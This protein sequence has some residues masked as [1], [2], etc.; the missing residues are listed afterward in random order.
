MADTIRGLTVEISADASSFNK[1]MSQM[2]KA[3]QSSQSELTALQ[4]SLDLEFDA[5]KLARAQ[6]VAQDAIDQTAANADALRRRL[7]YLEQ[8]GNIDTA[9]YSKLQTELAQTELK[10]QQLQKQLEKLNTLKFDKLSDQ[11][12]KIGSKI[13]GVGKALT[14]LSVAAAGV[15]TALGAAGTSAVKHAD[16]I[17]T[18]AT[19]YGTTA[20]AIQRFDY[21][22]LQ[23]DVDSENLYKALVKVRAGVADI[24]SG[25]TS[26]ASAALKKLR[27]DFNSFD[28]SEDQFYAIIDALASMEDQTQMVAIANDIFGD[29]LANS[30]LPLIY[31]GTDAVNEYCA[32]FET[33]GS[34]TNEQVA[35]LAE[36]DN[37]LNRIKTQLSNVKDQIGAALLPVMQAFADFVENNIVPKLQKLAGWFDSLSDS[38]KEFAVKALLVVAALAPLAIGIGKVVGAVGNVIKVLPQLGSALSALEAHPIIAIIGLIAM[39]LLLLYT[40][41][42]AFRDAINNLV[43]SLT[44]AL[45]PALEAVQNVLDLIMSFITPIIELVGGVLGEVINAITEALQP[46]NDILAEIFSLLQPIFDILTETI[47]TIL[48]PLQP[49]LSALF[50][51]LEPILSVALIPMKLVLQALQVPLKAIGTLL[52]WLAPL[53]QVFGNI[54]SKIFGGVIKIINLVLGVIEDA[55]NFVIGI[56]NGLVDGVNKALGW[57][58]VHIDRIAEVKLRIDTSDI[59]SMDDVNAI[60]DST[61]PDTSGGGTVYDDGKGSG[62]YGDQYNYD[63]STTNKTQNITVTIQNYAAEI[64]EDELVRKINTKLAEAM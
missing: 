6:K 14:P 42:E 25:A 39:I 1:E 37:V 31:A 7:E 52:G 64:D 22:A 26:A 16:E 18:L 45:Q 58:G 51:I 27:L 49:L 35:A 38:Q 43:D 62:T 12:T 53:F 44:S 8:T 9:E 54:V 34:M 48:A 32:E 28:G 13:E 17:A 40:R 36:F 56:I 11:V 5:T 19:Q 10:G 23:T 47:G 3:A 21:V 4:K 57:L 24:A 41:C 46:V 63:N 33:L 20:E 50:S 61:P 30:L 60:I 29:K 15:V 2:R 59:E 55:V